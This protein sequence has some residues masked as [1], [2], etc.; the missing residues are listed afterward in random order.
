MADVY[1]AMTSD[2]P[3][4][5]ALSHE[6]AVSELS[7]AAARS[8]TR[9]SKPWLLIQR[10]GLCLPLLEKA[11]PRLDGSRFDDARQLQLRPAWQS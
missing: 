11:A 2:R 3:Y 6:V 1:D 8:S 4:R 10:Q 5:R 9:Q 7:A